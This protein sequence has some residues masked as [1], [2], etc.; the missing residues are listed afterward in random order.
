MFVRAHR[1]DPQTVFYFDTYDN[2]WVARDGSL[3]WRTNN[4]GLVLT[5]ELSPA[6]C[7]KAI[8]H[9]DHVAIF[10]SAQQ[11]LQALK[12]WVGVQELAG[13]FLF[14]IAKRYQPKSPDTCLRDLCQL[15][16][17]PETC[18]NPILSAKQRTNLIQG[19]LKLTGFVDDRGKPFSL[20]PH[21]VGR[22]YSKDSKA[23]ERY[24]T[25]RD[26]L[27]TKNEAIE[28]VESHRLDAVIVC[29]EDGHVYLRSRP[30]RHCNQI[31]FS[32]HQFEK[33]VH[34]KDLTRTRGDFQRGQCIWA[35]INGIWNKGG[36][37][38]K[39]VKDLSSLANGQQVWSL[40]NNFKLFDN[41]TLWQCGEQKLGF[42]TQIVRS[43]AKFFQMLLELA[44]SDPS[45]PPVIIFLHS[46][47]AII[48]D[49]ALDHL[50]PNERSQLR[51]FT[52]G[53]GSLIAPGKA[54][55]DTH[56]YMSFADL[57]SKVA[58]R[59]GYLA[60]RRHQG[61][62]QGLSEQ[63]VIELL[64]EEDMLLYLDSDP[65]PTET[66][67]RQKC[68]E[69]YQLEFK[70]IANVTVLDENN[71][72]SI[73]EHSIAIPCYQEKLRK[74]IAHYLNERNQDLNKRHQNHAA[75]PKL[76]EIC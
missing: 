5:R 13:D 18:T 61:Q 14:R 1:F 71:T 60:F 3:A 48:G 49:L 17:V 8:S 36:K 7:L 43:A 9:H 47:G 2:K 52:F 35:Y 67:Y 25:S 46:Q 21:I 50:S 23:V 16:S 26:G 68:R 6:S 42:D 33:E 20:L 40:K 39:F 29:K 65:S 4:P 55:P 76:V 30:G 74:H 56:N 54:H 51:L 28:Q 62:S 22:F 19:I 70:T 57:V 15:L 32:E 41:G 64:V 27:F 11:G 63:Q 34:F 53:G 72:S 31:K 45:A 69:F 44:Q 59:T 12:D 24:L 66:Q 37:A 38:G 73:F 75:I 58:S 10:D